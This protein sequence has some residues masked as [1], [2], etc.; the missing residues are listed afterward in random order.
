MDRRRAPIRGTKRRF[1]AGGVTLA[2]AAGYWFPV[3]RWFGR[4]GTTPEELTRVMPGDVLIPDATDM[5]MQALTVDAPPEDIWPWLVQI[6]YRRGGLYSY[7][8]LDRL[9]GFLDRPS[10]TRIL[11]EFQRIA[12]G[13]SPHQ[14]FVEVIGGGVNVIRHSLHVHS[15]ASFD[16]VLQPVVQILLLAPLCANWHLK[17][18]Q[19]QKHGGSSF[20][21]RIR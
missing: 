3:R 20:H 18:L 21:S 6:G 13:E 10:A 16:V 17:P 14:F 1:L 8:W 7:D 15:A 9:F 11:P 2:L 19:W 5:S 4:W 12:V